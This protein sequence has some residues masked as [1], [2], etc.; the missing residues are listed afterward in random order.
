MMLIPDII[1]RLVN[2]YGTPRKEIA[3]IHGKTP[4]R[5]MELFAR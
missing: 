4:M 2:D 1:N 3:D 5:N